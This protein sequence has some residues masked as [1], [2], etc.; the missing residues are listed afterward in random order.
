MFSVLQWTYSLLAIIILDESSRIAQAYSPNKMFSCQSMCAA[1]MLSSR[2]YLHNFLLCFFLLSWRARSNWVDSYVFT[3]RYFAIIFVSYYNLKVT[4]HKFIIWVS[5]I[6]NLLSSEILI[7]FSFE[8][9]AAC[10]GD[11]NFPP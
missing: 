11:G 3:I 8:Y 6:N 5:L 10:C 1:D 2:P 4:G 9:S 7:Y